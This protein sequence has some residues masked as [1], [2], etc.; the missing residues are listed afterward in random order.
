MSNYDAETLMRA[1]PVFGG[2]EDGRIIRWLDTDTPLPFARD[3]WRYTLEIH[4]VLRKWVW[5]ARKVV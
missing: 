1:A 5:F 2:P 4:P 3:G